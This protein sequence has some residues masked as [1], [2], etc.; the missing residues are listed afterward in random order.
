MADGDCGDVWPTSVVWRFASYLTDSRQNSVRLGNILCFINDDG[1][2]IFSDTWI[3][4]S[5]KSNGVSVIHSG[6]AVLILE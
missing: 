2:F 5:P 3:G 6:L 1:G 4:F